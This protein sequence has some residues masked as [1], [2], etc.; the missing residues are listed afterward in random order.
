MSF[1]KT[2]HKFQTDAKRSIKNSGL[3][4]KTKDVGLWALH[5]PK[6]VKSFA[7]DFSKNIATDTATGAAGGTA[8]EPGGGTGVGAAGGAL[9]GIGETL[10]EHW[11]DLDDALSKQK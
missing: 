5:H 3:A 4:E 2:L 6:E 11:G 8:A 10:F 9:Y 7:K 1:S